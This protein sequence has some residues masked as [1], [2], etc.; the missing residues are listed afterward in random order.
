MVVFDLKRLYLYL[1]DHFVVLFEVNRT[2]SFLARRRRRLRLRLKLSWTGHLSAVSSGRGDDGEMGR[3]DIRCRVCRWI[4]AVCIG[5]GTA[6]EGRIIGEGSYFGGGRGDG[7]CGERRDGQVQRLVRGFRNVIL[8]NHIIVSFS[9]I[10]HH[11]RFPDLLLEFSNEFLQSF[12]RVFVRGHSPLACV[13]PFGLLVRTNWRLKISINKREIDCP[14]CY[15][16]DRWLAKTPSSNS[17]MRMRSIRRAR[18]FETKRNGTKNVF[19]VCEWRERKVL[20]RIVAK[21]R[22]AELEWKTSRAM[23]SGQDSRT[24]TSTRSSTFCLSV[25]RSSRERRPVNENERPRASCRFD[26]QMGIVM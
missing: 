19:T 21:D 15:A 17:Q 8:L 16:F 22:R 3:G 1:T 11:L 20:R 10:H 26:S 7:R 2:G 23:D 12:R 24:M 9:V 18:K 4:G 13:S 14:I 25:G 6:I 5:G